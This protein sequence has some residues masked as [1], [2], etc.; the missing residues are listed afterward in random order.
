MAYARPIGH[1]ADFANNH[2][3]SISQFQNAGVV[4]FVCDVA[5]LMARIAGERGGCELLKHRVLAN[6][7]YEPSTRTSCSFASAMQRLGGTVLQVAESSS[8]AAKGETLGDSVRALAC[9]SEVVVLRHPA[10]GA[11][12]EASAACPVPLLNAGDGV[13]EHPTQALL[14]FCTIHSELGGVAGATVTLVGD[15]KHGRTVH[16]LAR[17]LALCGVKKVNYVAPRACAP[18][19]LVH[20]PHLPFL[21]VNPPPP[22]YLL[23]AQRSSPCRRTS[24]SC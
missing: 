18:G 2:I 19:A 14:D 7:F 12:A 24:R 16:S 15:L 17:L 6:V 1:P 11:A 20:T 10:K 22:P 4:Q 8:S 23:P 9:Y 3:I 21:R 13:G 5:G